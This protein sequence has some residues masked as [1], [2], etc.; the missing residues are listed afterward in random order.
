MSSYCN[1]VDIN[2]SHSMPLIAVRSPGTH[3]LRI[4]GPSSRGLVEI[5]R[6]LTRAWR[7]PSAVGPIDLV[8]CDETNT[9]VAVKVT[10]R[11]EIAGVEHVTTRTIPARL[12]GR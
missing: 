4:S 2:S 9:V 10:R 7:V 5:H 11:D 3:R 12:V 6:S 8:Y 1:S